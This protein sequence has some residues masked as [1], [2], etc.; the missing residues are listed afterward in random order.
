MGE[1]ES[2]W[3]GGR[4]RLRCLPTVLCGKRKLLFAIVCFCFSFEMRVLL[5]YFAPDEIWHFIWNRA[6]V[7]ERWLFI[8]Y[9]DPFGKSHL[10]QG[11]HVDKLDVVRKQSCPIHCGEI[12]PAVAPLAIFFPTE[13]P[14]F[15]RVEVVILNFW[16]RGQKGAVCFECFSFSGRGLVTSC[17]GEFGEI[18][19][20]HR[21]VC[22]KK[23][24]I[25][26]PQAATSS[27][28][29]SALQ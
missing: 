11:S 2:V 14:P 17:G 16:A 5:L 6:A 3:D 24:H 1:F 23:K 10:M 25:I 4:F 26:P 7:C 21:Q 20:K 12:M 27:V 22:C 18:L 19:F 28:L 13:C 15:L 9:Y 8:Q 29:C